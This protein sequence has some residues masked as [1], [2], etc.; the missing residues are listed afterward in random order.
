MNWRLVLPGGAFLLV[1]AAC[2]FDGPHSAI[3]PS[4]I[5]SGA[6]MLHSSEP[7]DP[8]SSFN[9]PAIDS[10]SWTRNISREEARRLLQLQTEASRLGSTLARDYPGAFVS[11]GLEWD[12]TFRVMAYFANISVQE[13]EEIIKSANRSV[14]LSGLIKVELT[15]YSKDEGAARRDFVL[16]AVQSIDRSASIAY[17]EATGQ[18]K[19]LA[20]D[21]SNF[22][23]KLESADAATRDALMNLPIEKFGGI[24]LT[25]TE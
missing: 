9:D 1:L 5:G 25:A 14:V 20:K 3:P 21:P 6:A 8:F 24:I 23:A 13:A 19:I 16:Q 11:L 4:Q 12:P 2:S 10:L 17:R 18:I 15:P 7:F 22:K